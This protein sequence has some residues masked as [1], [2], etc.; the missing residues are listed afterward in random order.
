MA[1]APVLDSVTPAGPVTAAVG[2]KITFVVVAHDADTK[3]EVFSFTVT[4]A[5]GN[6]SAPSVPVTVNWVDALTLK[7][8]TNGSSPI[9]VS[10]MT[11]TVG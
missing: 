8:T 11:A 7:V 3:S 9:V 4:D 2:S 10:G 1:T 5:E 6:V